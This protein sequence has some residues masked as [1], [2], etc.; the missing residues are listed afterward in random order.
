MTKNLPK[1]ALAAS[2]VALVVSQLPLLRGAYLP[3][4]YVSSLTALVTALIAV[5]WSVLNFNQV[6]QE[7]NKLFWLMA[8]S[9]LVVF[10]IWF[11]IAS[12]GKHIG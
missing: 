10:W 11:W 4:F 1:V 5:G 3:L 12:L 8:S 2:I 7:R 9:T 6:K